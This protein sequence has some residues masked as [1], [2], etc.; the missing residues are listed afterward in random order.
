M[1]NAGIVE[2]ASARRGAGEWLDTRMNPVLLRDLRLYMRGK[3][4]LY[5]YFIVLACLTIVA[6]TGIVVSH[7]TRG[8]F[9][10]LYPT[11]MILA[12]A[13]GAMVPYLVG[14]R[15]RDELSSHATELIL[16]SPLTAARLVRG[17]VYGAWCL[18]L[19]LLSVAMPVFV[20]SYLL[21]G[22]SP[23]ALLI[24]FAGLVLAA[25]VMP[26]LNVYLGT[27]GRRPGVGRIVSALVLVGSFILM[28]CYGDA[29]YDQVAGGRYRQPGHIFLVG[30][31]VAGVLVA[32]FLYQVSVFRLRGPGLVREIRPRISLAVAALL[33]W[34]GTFVVVAWVDDSSPDWSE[35]NSAA[36]IAVA[37]AFAWGMVVLA[38]GNAV[39][40][41][42]RPGPG[43]TRYPL[44][45]VGPGSL[46]MYCSVCT[47]AI[48]LPGIASLLP[49]GWH[50][51]QIALS[52]FALAPLLAV[53]YGIAAYLLLQIWAKKAPGAN[54]LSRTI[55]VTNILL[56]V[57][58]FFLCTGLM[59]AG[60]VDGPLAAL[61][62]G[63]PVGLAY[64][65]ISASWYSAEFII[66]SGVAGTVILSGINLFLGWRH[67]ARERSRARVEVERRTGG[68]SGD[69]P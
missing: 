8:Y 42:P 3:L 18:S 1:S 63:T 54:S 38:R 30:Y 17:K 15:F 20:T 46:A 12:I 60:D 21:G 66:L 62:A 34:L 13:T 39:T 29:L 26:L 36:F 48:V 19:M 35:V 47:V 11:V 53:G 45:G 55:F 31:A 6:A 32:Q 23:Y 69:G 28:G 9:S 5:G 56:G 27:F 43:R 57:V 67:Q 25:T 65:M 59:L 49:A 4:F 37:W 10:L 64:L 16:A 68:R 24:I 2:A 41:P 22:I 7:S 44:T 61:L 14:E 50:R 33:G 51:V 52:G 40:P 58:V